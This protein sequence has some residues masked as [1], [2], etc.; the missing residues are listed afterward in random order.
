MTYTGDEQL[1]KAVIRARLGIDDSDS[2]AKQLQATVRPNGT[3][4]Y[5]GQWFFWVHGAGNSLW[6]NEN[7]LQSYDGRLRLAPV[8]LR[9]AALFG[10]LRAAGA[11]LVSAEIRA[12]GE[13][14]YV[15]LTSEAGRPCTL[16]NPWDSAV[17][18]RQWPSLEAVAAGQRGGEM[19]FETKTGA[20]YIIDRPSDPWEQQAETVVAGE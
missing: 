8:K 11:F 19:V 2:F 13:V 5:P 20:T 1:L 9:A 18:V 7:L 14:A 16:V 3:I 4:S 12:G 6:H 15:T 10:Q 17:R